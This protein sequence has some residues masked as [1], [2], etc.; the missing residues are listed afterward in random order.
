M[1]K[2]AI[3]G[4]GGL[5]KMHLKNVAKL[6]RE[7]G[8]I[9]L[10]ALCDVEE[11]R[12]TEK[13][14]INLGG[15]ATPTDLTGYRL[16]TDADE[17]LKKEELDFVMTALPTYVHERIAVQALNAGL[18]VFSEKPM[19][20]SLAECQNMV[21]RAKA[22]KRLLMIGQCLRYWPE[23]VKLKE[24][25]DS[26]KYGKV[27][28]AEFFRYSSPPRWAWQN[29]FLDFEKSG[30]AALDMHVHDVDFIN[31]VFGTPV[32]VSSRATH[33]TSKFDS[34][35][36]SYDFANEK[37]VTS[38]GDWGLP[39][40]YAFSASYMVKFENAA[41]EMRGGVTKVYPEDGEAFALEFPVEDAYVNEVCDFIEC[42]KA[43]RELTVVTPESA[44][45]TIKIVT[46]EMESA[47]R[48]VPVNV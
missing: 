35:V 13:I 21:D 16:Y 28:R 40:S 46:A 45:Q 27:L 19:A 30:G 41:V 24:F 37:V 42:I 31:W 18:H 26:R 3:I 15:D 32:K 38:V 36:T 5:G 8:D 33:V 10:T 9:K 44:M 25:I 1:L 47:E 7:R 14:E 29:W 48:G 11:S 34:I 39:K 23:Y 6:E 22:N 43:G 2:F 4:V 20:R 17:L 12:F